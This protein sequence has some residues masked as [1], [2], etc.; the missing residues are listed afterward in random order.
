LG[1]QR[2]PTQNVRSRIDIGKV[3]LR[4]LVAGIENVSQLSAPFMV[5]T[6]DVRDFLAIRRLRLGQI[7]AHQVKFE[8]QRLDR[9]TRLRSE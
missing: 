9:R 5:L 4:Q 6:K 7:V 1:E 2:S 8:T 3:L